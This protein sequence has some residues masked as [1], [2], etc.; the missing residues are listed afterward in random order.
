MS[1]E[2]KYPPPGQTERELC[3]SDG[4]RPKHFWT[5]STTRLHRYHWIAALLCRTCCV[6]GRVCSCCEARAERRLYCWQCMH[7][8]LSG[9]ELVQRC[10]K[11]GYTNA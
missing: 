2:F 7:C 4:N 6:P 9:T 11:F 5:A 8:W 3:D 1:P 10:P